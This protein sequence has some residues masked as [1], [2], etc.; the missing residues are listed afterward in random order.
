MSSRVTSEAATVQADVDAV[1]DSLARAMDSFE[2]EF[3]SSDGFRVV[4]REHLA[5]LTFHMIEK[6]RE[7][8]CDLRAIV[9]GFGD[10]TGPLSVEGFERTFV[11]PLASGLIVGM[12]L[13]LNGVLCRP[14]L[15]RPVEAQGAAL[16][17]RNAAI[18]GDSDTVDAFS[19]K[20]LGL[21]HPAR[22]RE[23]VETALLGDWVAMLGTGTATKPYVHDLLQRHADVQHRY[24][25]PVWEGKIKGEHTVLLAQ[26]VDEARTIADLLVDYRTPEQDL[27]SKERDIRVS[28]VLKHLSADELAMA[29]AWAE[30]GDPWPVVA[31]EL[32]RERKFGERVRCKLSRLGKRHA[33]RAAEAERTTRRMR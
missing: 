6:V 11:A 14:F 20:V 1:F 30:H 16:I 28:K 27:L 3:E 10:E 4:W 8:I 9:E 15:V 2:A 22:W 24:L 33:D 25:Q 32:S 12:L 19:R 5:S 7:C 23:A 17:A 18:E 29:L 31:T 13:K 21:K 26:P